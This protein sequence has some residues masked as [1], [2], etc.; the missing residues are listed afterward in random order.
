MKKTLLF[1][2]LIVVLAVAGFAY[3]QYNKPHRD[4]AAETPAYTLTAAA[5]FAEYSTDEAA[6][7]AKYV[8]KLLLVRGT[9]TGI[10]VAEDSTVSIMLQ[11]A[12]PVFGVGFRL[13][14]AEAAKIQGLQVGDKVQLKGICTGKLMDVVLVRGVLVE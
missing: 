6:A 12:D 4:T 1:V 7:N 5:L 13:L 8:D 3:L 9:I 14:P 11:T 10:S 2:A